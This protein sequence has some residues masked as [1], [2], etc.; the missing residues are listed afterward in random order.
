MLS[1]MLRNGFPMIA[2]I[3]RFRGIAALVL[4]L[5]VVGPRVL[6]E[7]SVARQEAPSP[8]IAVFIN[9]ED[10]QALGGNFPLPRR[11]LA[12]AIRAADRAEARG[13]VL[14]FFI[15][16]PAKDL[17]DDAAL[18]D[19]LAESS[20]PVVLQANLE[21]SGDPVVLA[22]R[23]FRPDLP[24][25]RAVP[26]RNRGWLPLPALAEHATAVGFIDSLRPV[27]LR[28]AYQGRAVPS[29]FLITLELALGPAS[30]Q[31]GGVRFAG[32]PGSLELGPIAG[33][34]EFVDDLQPLTLRSL[35]DGSAAEK[36]R[37]KVVVLGYDGA[38][39]HALPTPSGEIKA[40]RLFFYQLEYLFRSVAHGG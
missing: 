3:F 36:V 14:K 28:E 39:M 24:F 16:L 20:M 22:D 34:A 30:V 15:D 13:L 29:L 2:R 27:Y 19:A 17:R 10:V 9:D 5:F 12:D 33:A 38:K 6:A 40:H 11:R 8:F 7:T 21:P 18:K 26:N 23:F 35:L 37:G 4:S 1:R 31:D 25:D 32:T